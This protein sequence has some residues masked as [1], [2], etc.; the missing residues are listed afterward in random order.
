MSS[1]S[2]ANQIDT[3]VLSSGQ[4]DAPRRPNRPQKKPGESATNIILKRIGHLDSKIADLADGGHDEIN[5]QIS[6]SLDTQSQTLVAVANALKSLQCSLV[7]AVTDA[8]DGQ[9]EKRINA[10]ASL[11]ANAESKESTIVQQETAGPS[12]VEQPEAAQSESSWADI[13]SAFLASHGEH[14]DPPASVQTVDSIDAGVTDANVDRESITPKQ[15]EPE[16]EIPEFKSVDDP[17]SLNEDDL[18]TAVINQERTISLLVSRL[19]VK[20]RRAQS[21]TTAQLEEVKESLPEELQRQ[22]EET[23]MALRNQLRFGELELSLERARVARQASHLE[24]TR[25][26]LEARASAMGL[27]ISEE[28]EIVGGAQRSSKGRNWLGAMGFGN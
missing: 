24:V 18:R 11:S 23:I 17:H 6:E 12:D 14:G 27:E 20:S 4:T 19:Q 8:I 22:V 25:E 21:L 13:R 7:D 1:S 2:P 26:R 15:A 16:I 5:I 10:P 9:L 28:G 3:T